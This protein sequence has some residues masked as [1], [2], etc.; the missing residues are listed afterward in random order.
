MKR[1]K[2]KWRG[3]EAVERVEEGRGGKA[4]VTSLH[5]CLEPRRNRAGKEEVVLGFWDRHAPSSP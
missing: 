2:K 3:K 1:R 5:S 4:S